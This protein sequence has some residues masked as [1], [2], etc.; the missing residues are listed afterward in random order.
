MGYEWVIS[1]AGT[2]ASLLAGVF[3]AALVPHARGRP[4]PPSQRLS[5]MLGRSEPRS[6]AGLGGRRLACAPAAGHLSL[7]VARSGRRRRNG[8][9]IRSCRSHLAPWLRESCSIWRWRKPGGAGRWIAQATAAT[10]TGGLADWRGAWTAT[11]DG[12]WDL[13]RGAHGRQWARSLLERERQ[14]RLLRA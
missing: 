1:S 3:V 2:L 8:R 13:G 9:R 12:R 4:D 6:H 7:V 5:P 11:A 10:R 14:R